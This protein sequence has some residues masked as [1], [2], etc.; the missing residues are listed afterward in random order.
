MNKIINLEIFVGS[1]TNKQEANDWVVSTF[2]LSWIYEVIA[3]KKNFYGA[4]QK[5]SYYRKWAPQI[6]N[7]PHFGQRGKQE[8]WDQVL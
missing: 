8:I 1:F 3:L 7:A 4:D 2:I 6:G 5:N